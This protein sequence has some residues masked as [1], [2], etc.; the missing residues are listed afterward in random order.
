MVRIGNREHLLTKPQT[1][2]CKLMLVQLLFAYLYDLRTMD[3]ENSCESGWTINKLC[4]FLSGFVYHDSL[5]DCLLNLYR[6]VMIY[7]LY[8]NYKLA[9]KVH[10]D[11]I[12]ILEN[13]L[14]AIKLVAEVKYIFE[15]SDPR[16]LLNILYID[17]LIVFAQNMT[18]GD[19]GSLLEQ[20]SEAKVSK[21]SLQLMLEQFEAEGL[22]LEAD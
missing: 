7:P 14:F 13:K 1:V 12:R 18:N 22:E 11:L 17:D 3:W 19:W 9:V 21:N 16:Y 15:K 8:R 2:T 6:R 10:K 4:P 20:V 5:A